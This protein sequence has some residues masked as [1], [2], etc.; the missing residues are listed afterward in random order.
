MGIIKTG[1]STHDAAC[2]TAEQIRQ[3]AQVLGVSQASAASADITYLRACRDSAIA[4]G[5]QSE[6][7]RAAL[8]G[9]HGLNA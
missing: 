4:N 2:L 1:N 7:F 9:N 3:V 6:V 8:K 5:L